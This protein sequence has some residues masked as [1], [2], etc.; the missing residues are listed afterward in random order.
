[1]DDVEIF[2]WVCGCVPR[3]NITV[4]SFG[5]REREGGGSIFLPSISIITTCPIECHVIESFSL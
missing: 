1:M 4:N 2:N 3:A 5:E